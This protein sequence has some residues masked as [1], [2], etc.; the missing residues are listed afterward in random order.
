MKRVALVGFL[1]LAF[2]LGLGSLAAGA[3]YRPIV[4]AAAAL[5][6]IGVSVRA[7]LRD[8]RFAQVLLATFVI[9]ASSIAFWAVKRMLLDGAMATYLAHYLL[10]AAAPLV[11]LQH[12]LSVH[13]HRCE[14]LTHG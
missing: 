1:C 5:R 13:R 6:L 9:P 12:V 8:F 7:T 2:W 14:I 4:L 10:L 11:I 3:I